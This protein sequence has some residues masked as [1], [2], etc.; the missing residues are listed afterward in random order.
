MRRTDRKRHQLA[1]ELRKDSALQAE[2][3]AIAQHGLQG[4][5]SQRYMDWK[6]EVNA[7]ARE[8]GVSNGVM[9]ERVVKQ[10]LRTLLRARQT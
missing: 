7:L 9:L 6:H 1:E 10:A 3:K 8:L 4:K 2:V 5:P